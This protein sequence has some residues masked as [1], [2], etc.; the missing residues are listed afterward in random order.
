MQQE[1]VMVP[2]TVMMQQMVYRPRTI[3]ESV[4]AAPVAL[5]A[6]PQFVPPSPAPAAE[7][8]AVPAPQFAPT[9]D[10][11]GSPNTQLAL[12]ALMMTTRNQAAQAGARRAAAAPSADL[13]NRVT[14]LEA[15][16]DRL[17]LALERTK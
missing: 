1:A 9:R 15:K 5:P 6:P 14:A 11:A 17:I 7:P 2:V 4:P 3:L 10:C 13:Q 16:M 12:M 8:A